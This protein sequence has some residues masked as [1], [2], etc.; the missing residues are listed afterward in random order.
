M[1]IIFHHSGQPLGKLEWLL[2]Q[3]GV[4]CSALEKQLTLANNQLMEHQK[5]IGELEEKLKHQ[6]ADLEK[7]LKDQSDSSKQQKADLEKKLKEQTDSNA[8]ISSALVKAK[9]DLA[10]AK[11]KVISESDQKLLKEYK[12]RTL[13]HAMVGLIFRR[14]T[15]VEP[16]KIKVLSYKYCNH[17]PVKDDVVSGSVYEDDGWTKV[18]FKTNFPKDTRIVQL[19][20]LEQSTRV[21]NVIHL[22]IRVTTKSGE[23][24]YDE[25]N[26]LTAIA[27]ESYLY[28]IQ[29]DAKVL[30]KE[31]VVCLA[32]RSHTG[33]YRPDNTAICISMRAKSG[34]GEKLTFTERTQYKS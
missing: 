11:S 3:G 5:R 32:I 28:Y 17:I 1:G 20:V 7:K 6:K 30:T 24:L 26:Y 34:I 16:S 21:E 29:A 19:F 18:G 13:H 25:D 33:S 14:G 27:N 2:P 15:I 10:V 9:A 31:F 22:M 23:I 12:S 8:G 4:D